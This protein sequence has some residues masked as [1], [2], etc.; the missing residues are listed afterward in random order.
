MVYA[1]KIGV[2]GVGG[3]VA[4]VNDTTWCTLYKGDDKMETKQG[5]MKWS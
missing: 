2:Y 1:N 4:N 5:E 3:N